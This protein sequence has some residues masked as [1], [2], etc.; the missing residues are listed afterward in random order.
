MNVPRGTLCGC[1]AEERRPGQRLGK[2]CHA[3]RMRE[4]RASKKTELISL[5]EDAA[6]W[7]ALQKEQT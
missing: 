5:K 3:K 2:L 6:K 4:H 1:G 7:R